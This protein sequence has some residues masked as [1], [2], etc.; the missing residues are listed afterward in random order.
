LLVLFPLLLLLLLAIGRQRLAVLQD[1]RCCLL[2][3]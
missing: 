1:A 2:K 3:P